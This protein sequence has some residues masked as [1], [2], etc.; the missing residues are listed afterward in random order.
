MATKL[1]EIFLKDNKF[2]DRKGRDIKV[3][4]IGIPRIIITKSKK[5]F[6]ESF[7]KS[8]SFDDKGAKYFLR[9]EGIHQIDEINRLTE[10]HRFYTPVQ[11]YGE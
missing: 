1:E 11:L 6:D 3:S 4:P 8:L 7:N 9:G 5:G 10:L 2:K